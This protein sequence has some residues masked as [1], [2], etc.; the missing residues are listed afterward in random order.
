MKVFVSKRVNGNKVLKALDVRESGE[1]RVYSY[2]NTLTPVVGYI[3]KYEAENG[4]TKVKGIKGLEK[5][6]DTILN[7]TTDGVLSGKRDVLSYITFDKDS[8]MKQRIDGADLYLN[9]SLKLQKNVEMILD[10]YKKQLK[11]DEIIVS[12]MES[13][14]GKVISFA[15]SNRFNPSRILQ[16]DIPSLNVKGI[17]YPFEPGSVIKPITIS[18][19]LDKNRV[20]KTQLFSAY[21]KKGKANKKGEYPKGK[22]KIGRHTIGDDHR[23]KKHLLT[24]EDIVVFS[25]NIGTLQLAQKLSGKE[26]LEGMKS[27]GFAKRSGIEL[28]YERTGIFPSLKQLSAGESRNEDNVYKAT[29]S[30]GQGMTSTFMQVLKAYTVFNNEGKISTPRLLSHISTNGRSNKYI[31]EEQKTIISKKTAKTIKNFLVQTVEKGT[32]R[33]AKIEGLEI[34][35]KTGTA[36]IVQRGQYQKKYISSFFGFANDK[37]TSYTIGVT[38]FNPNSKG[39]NWYQYYASKSAVP[40]FKELVN[41]LLQQNYLKK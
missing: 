25:S 40:V 9:I 10:I 5:K 19:V 20:K 31:K 21:N 32:G 26:I 2:E 13:K 24:I 37:K 17:E 6:F 41:I 34:G 14:T 36:Q 15:S 3:R 1:K 18:L 11:A 12:I 23:F 28:P 30:Y 33:S 4:K 8:T 22:Y 27:Y 39:R 35:G 38:V 29:V 7:N 16:S